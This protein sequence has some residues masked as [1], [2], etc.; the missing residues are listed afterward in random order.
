MAWNEQHKINSKEKILASAAQLFT[1]H[2]F[3]KVSINQVMSKAKM[4]R[5]AFYSHFTSKSDLYAQS[6]VTA[7]VLAKKDHLTHCNDNFKRL[8]QRYLS[9]EHRNESIEN[10]CPLA[11]LVSDINQQDTQVKNTYTKVFEGFINHAH[12]YADSE[13]SALQAA[14][15]MIGGLALAKA[16]NDE[17]L[18]DKLLIACQ[19]GVS[20]LL[21]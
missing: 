7:G 19:E 9:R 3:E 14:T 1:R 11:F 13:Q 2:G 8:T 5:G 21:K 17:T 16:I 4:T 10:V 20:S 12:Q 18:S 15:L 6:I